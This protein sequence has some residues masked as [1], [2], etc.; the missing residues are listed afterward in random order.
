MTLSLVNAPRRAHRSRV[1]FWHIVSKTIRTVAR[2]LC[3]PRQSYPRL[4][5]HL[6]RDIGLDAG[7]LV[8]R[9]PQLPSQTSHHPRG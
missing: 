6:A 2:K 7:D 3:D 9:D 5:D 4:S 8:W 1:K